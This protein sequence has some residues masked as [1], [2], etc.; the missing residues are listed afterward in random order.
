MPVLG[1][2]VKGAVPHGHCSS[3]AAVKRN[4]VA[5]MHTRA[6]SH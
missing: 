1:T 2:G 6:D 3:G 4:P 5:I